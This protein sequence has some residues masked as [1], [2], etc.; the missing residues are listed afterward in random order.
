MKELS[1]KDK[2][3]KLKNISSKYRLIHIFSFM[4]KSRGL[5]MVV[6]NKSLQKKLGLTLDSFKNL[7]R[8]IFSK[9]KR[10]I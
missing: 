9:K 2:T 4:T 6:H 10:Y 3:N 8:S 7:K 1:Q 5:N